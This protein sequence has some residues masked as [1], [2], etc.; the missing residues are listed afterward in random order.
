MA[1]RKII[2]FSSR[3]LWVDEDKVRLKS[4]EEV[5]PFAL[6]S[7]ILIS[8]ISNLTSSYHFFMSLHLPELAWHWQSAKKKISEGA[9]IVI[10][11]S[12]VPHPIISLNFTISCKISP[13]ESMRK[14]YLWGAQTENLNQ[15]FLFFFAWNATTFFTDIHRYC[16]IIH[17]E[18][19][20]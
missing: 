7:I 15:V 3:E 13:S 18:E 11:I 17:V 16:N 10:E 9:I 1:S 20:L 6:I 4:T 2:F 8:P 5:A 14:N 19:N 12:H